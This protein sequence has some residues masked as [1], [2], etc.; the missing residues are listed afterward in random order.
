MS[1]DIDL[2]H[3][4]DLNTYTQYSRNAALLPAYA[5]VLSHL[6]RILT[7]FWEVANFQPRTSTSTYSFG[8]T[9]TAKQTALILRLL[10]RHLETS[11][12]MP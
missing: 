10:H 11:V 2:L 1:C 7:S 6:N 5:V 12:G 8:R 9:N 4:S 3:T